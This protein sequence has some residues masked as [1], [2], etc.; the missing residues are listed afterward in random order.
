MLQWLQHLFSRRGIPQLPTVG[1]DVTGLTLTLERHTRAIPWQAITRIAAFKQDLHTH[2]RVVL[3]IEVSSS[4]D[5]TVTISED[6]PGFSDLF[7]PMEEAL[8]VNPRWY[9]D[10]MAPAFEPT[11]TVLYLSSHSPP[12]P[13]SAHG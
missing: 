4:G 3:L 7:G 12:E 8:G 1:A 11:P 6:C 5:P 9:L 10:I 13:T 2:D